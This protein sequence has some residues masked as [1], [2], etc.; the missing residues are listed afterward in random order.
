MNMNEDGSLGRWLIHI[1]FHE[2]KEPF[3]PAIS[4]Y[5]K[6]HLSLCVIQ[7]HQFYEFDFIKNGVSGASF[8][9]GKGI[10]GE[11]TQ[12]SVVALTWGL[13]RESNVI[14]TRRAGL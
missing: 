5:Q 3:S 14:I 13:E 4:E 6:E 2:Q 7:K 12:M 11:N 8:G 9:N 1:C 10:F